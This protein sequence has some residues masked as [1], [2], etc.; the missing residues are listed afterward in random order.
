MQRQENVVAVLMFCHVE[1]RGRGKTSL[2]ISVVGQPHRLPTQNWAGEAPALQSRNNRKPG[3][4]RG[5]RLYNRVSNLV[6]Q[7]S[8]GDEHRHDWPGRDQT[9]HGE[10]RKFNQMMPAFFCAEELAA[11]S[12]E[13]R[14]FLRWV[15]VRGTRL[16]VAGRLEIVIH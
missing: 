12:V 7:A 1:S 14:R 6:N 11:Q 3:A 4:R 10:G 15:N 9:E 5:E 8:H 2:D 16:G 13:R